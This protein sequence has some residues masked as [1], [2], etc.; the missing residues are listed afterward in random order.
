MRS[1]FLCLVT[2]VSLLAGT[3]L[4]ASEPDPLGSVN[5]EGVRDFAFGSA[6]LVFDNKHV[7]LDVPRKVEDGGQVPVAVR[8][9]GLGEVREIVVLADLNP[10]PRAVIFHPLLAEPRLALRIKVNEATAVRAAALTSDG[11][12]HVVGANVDAPGGGCTTASVSQSAQSWKTQLNRVQGQVWHRAEGGDRLRLRIIHPMNTGFVTN[13]P[14]FFID[15]LVVKTAEG[16]AVAEMAPAE[17]MAENPTLT[18]DLTKAGSSAS[19]YVVEWS[20]TDGNQGSAKI[21]PAR[22]TLAVEGAL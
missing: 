13:I 14:A 3:S 22:Q 7:I 4:S 9:V 1:A 15:H 19:G 8:V 10:A 5:W 2:A 16:R 21:A 18:V 6:P 11:V 17:P 12:W 20:D